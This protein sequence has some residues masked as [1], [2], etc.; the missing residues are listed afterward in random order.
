MKQNSAVTTASNPWEWVDRPRRLDAAPHELGRWQA[1]RVSRS[2]AGVGV[3]IPPA[4]L[5]QISRGS[6]CAGDESIDIKFALTAIQI[7][8]EERQAK[9]KRNRRVGT[10]CL[11]FLGLVLV[12]L[13]LLICLGLLML[14]TLEHTYAF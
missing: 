14:A 5:Q 6:I 2:F 9:R 3:A 7:A 1:H 11:L 13:N 10:R 12:A 4:R 8:R